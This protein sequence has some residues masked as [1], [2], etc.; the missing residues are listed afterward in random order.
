MKN[1]KINF[2][3]IK[4][5]LVVQVSTLM[6]AG[7][8]FN[9][10]YAAISPVSVG[11][12]F[13][14]TVENL[15]I[16]QNEIIN[17]NDVN[18]SVYGVESNDT[19]IQHTVE[20][21]GKIKVN[22]Y[23][24][25]NRSVI[26]AGIYIPDVN[27]SASII[28]NGNIEN[29]MTDVN[30]SYGS[31]MAGIYTKET[32]KNTALN[33][34]NNGEINLNSSSENSTGM[35]VLGINVVHDKI[36]DSNISNKGDININIKGRASGAGVLLSDINNTVLSN[37][38]N[39]K[40]DSNFS[41]MF[42]SGIYIGNSHNSEI[43]NNGNIEINSSHGA[44]SN[45]ILIT[46]N[47]IDSNIINTG[48]ISIEADNVEEGTAA[49]AVNPKNEFGTQ[50]SVYNSS[51]INKNKI[52]LKGADNNN[53][54]VF[55]I[56]APDIN[57]SSF[58]ND[59][60]VD[61]NAESSLSSLFDIEGGNINDTVIKNKKNV[62]VTIN[63]MSQ[64]Y[65]YHI[66]ADTN[67]TVISNEGTINVKAENSDVIISWIEGD[68]YENSVVENTGFIN[69]EG[70]NSGLNEDA[71]IWNNSIGIWIGSGMYDNS[72]LINSGEM[73]FNEY[74]VSGVGGIGANEMYNNSSII[75][76]GTININ[77]EYSDVV[78]GMWIWEMHDNAIFENRGDI[79]IT[80]KGSNTIEGIWA[81]YLEGN[82]TVKNS[83][84]IIIRG[85][86]N[87]EI[88]GVVL[89]NMEENATFINTGLIKVTDTNTSTLKYSVYV[90][91]SSS[92]EGGKVI[93]RG[94]M[95]GSVYVESGYTNLNF[96]N[97]GDI[98]LA[99]NTDTNFTNYTQT[100]SGILELALQTDGNI[101]N[102]SVS[103]VK[104]KNITF[105]DGS[106]V[107]IN[108]TADSTNEK[109]IID[110]NLTNVIVADNNLDV[111]V[112]KLNVTDNSALLKFVPYLD[113]NSLNFNIVKAL[114]IKNAINDSGEDYTSIGEALDT[115]QNMQTSGELKEFLDDLNTLE[116]K[117]EVADAAIQTGPVNS[118]VTPL[119]VSL[120]ME[121]ISNIVSSYQNS[122]RGLNSG[123]DM[124][125]SQNFWMKP[126]VGKAIQDNKDGKKGFDSNIYGVGI[127]YDVEYELD[128]RAGIAFFATKTDTDVND[129][130]QSSKVDAYTVIGYG[131]NM[132]NDRDNLS[133]QL[134]FGI[135]KTKS[136]RNIDLVHLTAHSDYDV[137][138]FGAEI[139]LDRR[140]VVNNNSCIYPSIGYA[141]RYV[142]VPSYTESGA[143]TLNL[144]VNSFSSQ[145]GFI[146]AGFNFRH[147]LKEENILSFNMG[148]GYNTINTNK[149]VSANF[150]NVSDVSFE[151][152]GIDNGRWKANAGIDYE[153]SLSNNNKLNI[154]GE[155]NMRGSG[156]RSY[157]GSFRYE[158]DF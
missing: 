33:I 27:V 124:F 100:S 35:S 32:E 47:L 44:F 151:T 9:S 132:L 70:N 157:S 20:N 16:N 117:R 84:N 65:G 74:N 79:N 156:F 60:D 113:A 17:V 150:E 155:Y 96:I 152:D 122:K 109:G 8:V 28:N 23:N 125:V 21:N 95:E 131:N 68:L 10:L 48:K 51:I 118:A 11:R 38:G 59:G 62:N 1:K 39:I 12:E 25:G 126:F 139:K 67:K 40:L 135:Q 128:K 52:S 58:I 45:G 138:V 102:T 111:N 107:K 85:T 97:E 147:I 91:D 129:V 66:A 149:T 31:T 19:L 55:W 71:R 63:N 115:L 146:N 42:I 99:L 114:T 13:N 134:S 88:Y 34:Q 43:I 130:P 4:K 24:E 143:G 2:K 101:S 83:G 76:S 105:E 3:I 57:K 73:N 36:T 153:I 72:K 103:K 18:K 82:S 104:G 37:D 5:G 110:Q 93:N 148:I 120:M 14:G 53:I 140:Y 30:N 142:K 22:L 26:S 81:G 46:T 119:V 98:K 141:Y 6:L 77:A 61:I 80:S 90:Y 133:Y 15:I 108:I 94:T 89:E 137:K 41:D 145:E 158:W 136:D 92:D 64:F 87:K 49:F 86:N 112:S 144:H 69:I 116:S 127:G 50:N 75:N 154:T 106:T 54:N 29:N 56:Y 7:G 121:R 78:I 123:D